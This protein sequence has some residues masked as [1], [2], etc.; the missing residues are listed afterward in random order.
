M[1]KLC[2]NPDD[3][4]HKDTIYVVNINSEDVIVPR[5]PEAKFDKNDYYKNPKKY[6]VTLFLLRVYS[7]I[8]IYL[9]YLRCSIAFFGMLDVQFTLKTSI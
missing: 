1:Q 5:D 9:T 8:S 7:R 6:K 4:A 3:P 2:E